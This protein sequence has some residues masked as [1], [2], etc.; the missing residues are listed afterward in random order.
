MEGG[1]KK[2]D[3][4]VLDYGAKLQKREPIPE[5]LSYDQI[6]DEVIRGKRTLSPQQMRLLIEIYPY[7]RPKLTAVATTVMDGQ[8]FGEL[9]DKA[10]QRVERAKLPPP[11]DLTPEPVEPLPTSVALKPFARRRV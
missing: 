11:I 8:S 10:I 1:S 9:L 4:W 5:E 2:P 7:F 6:A 3:G